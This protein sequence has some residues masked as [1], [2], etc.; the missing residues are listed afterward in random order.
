MTQ[1][2]YQGVE[3]EIDATL[4]VACH[5]KLSLA[6][7]SPNVQGPVRRPPIQPIPNCEKNAA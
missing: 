6:A 1:L 2:L 4:H 7:A 3:G 5:P